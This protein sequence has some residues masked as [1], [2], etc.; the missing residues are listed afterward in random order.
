M[1]DESRFQHKKDNVLSMERDARFYCKRAQRKQRMQDYLSAYENYRRALSFD[2]GD[3]EIVREYAEMLCEMSLYDQA[4]VMIVPFLEARH[5]ALA[6]LIASRAYVGIADFSAAAR[7]FEQFVLIWGEDEPVEPKDAAFASVRTADF[8]SPGDDPEESVSPGEEAHGGISR[9]GWSAESL[10]DREQE[11]REPK[12]PY[13]S[14]ILEVVEAL[15]S[16]V[17]ELDDQPSDSSYLETMGRTAMDAGH[18]EGALRYFERSLGKLDEAAPQKTAY[19]LR[20]HIALAHF[21]AGRQQKGIEELQKVLGEDPMNFQA[22]CNIVLFYHLSGQGSMA[23]YF[24][25]RLFLLEPETLEDMFKLAM[26]FAELGYHLQANEMLEYLYEARPY[27]EKILQAYATTCFNLRYFDQAVAVWNELERIAP[28]TMLGEYYIPL[29]EQCKKTPDAFTEIR[30]QFQVPHLEMIR[31]I[32]EIKRFLTADNAMRKEQWRR[33]QRMYHLLAWGFGLAHEELSQWILYA[34]VQLADQR[35]EMLLR[36]LL[37]RR[38]T[39]PDLL[40]CTLIALHNIGAQGPF[41]MFERGSIVSVPGERPAADEPGTRRQ[42]EKAEQICALVL[43]HTAQKRTPSR[44]LQRAPEEALIYWAWHRYMDA[45]ARR[46]DVKIQEMAL[47]A[48]ALDECVQPG[49]NLNDLAREY[50]VSRTK[51]ARIV[52]HMKRALEDR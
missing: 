26:T 33:D 31:R 7:C 32:K 15:Q 9:R 3:F 10:R 41:M 22:L 50:G 38:M 11:K 19:L 36:Y 49:Q 43:E 27:D 46:I 48:A 34:L 16:E 44:S 18:F 39:R 6:Y 1:N 8:V 5:D 4:I 40:R 20:N 51:L 2:P 29:A 35:A 28:E 23:N 52:F 12:E 30:Y 17:S 14:M 21:C 13:R 25:E 45:S 47:W 24:V 42:K 37:S